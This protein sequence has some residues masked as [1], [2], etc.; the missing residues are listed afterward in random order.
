MQIPE[1]QRPTFPIDRHS[2]QRRPHLPTVGIDHIEVGF[3]A[4]AAVLF[5]Q[6]QHPSLLRDLPLQPL[7]RTRSCLLHDR[8]DRSQ[9]H[10]LAQ[11]FGQTGLNAP[12]AGVSFHQ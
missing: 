3:A 12:I 11:E 7:L 1:R 10:L 8:R 6:G 5:I 4:F 9:A 2:R